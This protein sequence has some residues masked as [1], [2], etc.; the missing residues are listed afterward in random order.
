M[1]KRTRGPDWIEL[2]ETVMDRRLLHEAS[3]GRNVFIWV[4]AQSAQSPDT[5][6]ATGGFGHLHGPETF[7]FTPQLFGAAVR[8]L[9][10]AFNGE[11]A[12]LTSCHVPTQS[13]CVRFLQETA[14]T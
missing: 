9:K 12:D 8:E 10:S 2:M 4:S 5:D 3:T 11:P 1:G 6:A 14:P 13:V 7:K